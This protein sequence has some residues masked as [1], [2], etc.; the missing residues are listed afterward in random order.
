[1]RVAASGTIKVVSAHPWKTQWNE[2]QKWAEDHAE[3]DPRSPVEIMADVEFLYQNFPE[4]VR[5]IDPDPEKIGVQN[6]HRVF[7]KL[8]RIMDERGLKF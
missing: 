4:D 2:Y 6:L 8:Q 7:A 5:R 3:P 1:M